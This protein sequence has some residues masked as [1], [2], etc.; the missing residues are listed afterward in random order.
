MSR[1]VEKTE[2]ADLEEKF[3][4]MYQERK[5]KEKIEKLK[6][7]KTSLE[8]VF[9]RIEEG[10]LKDLNLILKADVQG[11]VEAVKESLIR[12]SNDE[13]KVHIVDSVRQNGFVK[14]IP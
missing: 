7:R 11:S 14:T 6:A 13:V 12:L 4:K 10:K 3:E 1:W 2:W 9:S 5:A 8:D